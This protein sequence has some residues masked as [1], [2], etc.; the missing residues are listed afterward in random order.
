[1]E[2]VQIMQLLE[3]DPIL[4]MLTEDQQRMLI[5]SAEFQELPAGSVLLHD[6]LLD[7]DLYWLVQ[8]MAK[9]TFT[10]DEGEEIT[11]MFYH[12]GELI[13]LVSAIS[14]R[15]T[16]FS[17]QTLVDSKLY[18][19]PH[20]LF[21]QLLHENY[22]FADKILRVISQRFDILYQEIQQEHSIYA[23][24]MDP[25]PYRK[26]VGEIMTSP[27]ITAGESDSLLD[28]TRSM[29]RNRISSLVITGSNKEVKGIITREDIIRTIATDPQ[30]F[31]DYQARE[32]M[33]THLY[34]L[35]PEA[36][37]YEALLLMA[38]YQI[39]H[40]PIVS[41]QQQLEG[42][43]TIRNLTEARGTNILTVVQ[44]IESA[45]SL[46]EL[47]SN[48]KTIVQILD[49]MSR[50]N[51][52]ALEMCHVI[53]ECNDR[54]TRRILAI[55]EQQLRDEGLGEPPV[56]YCWLTMGSEGR[57]E[58]A[59]GT[60]QDNAIIYEDVTAEKQEAVDHYFAQ[61]AE[62]VVSALEQ[63]GFPRC[64]GNVMATNPKWR[65]SL[66]DWKRGIHRWLESVEGEE[67]RNFT[68]FLDF[69]PVYGQFSLAEEVRAYLIGLSKSDHFLLHRL[70]EDDAEHQVPLGVFGRI[71][72]GKENAQQDR[73]N[74]KHGGVMHIV[75][76]MRIFALREG[77]LE[78]STLD[79]LE[80]LSQKSL[81]SKED[82][83]NIKEA[84]NTFMVLRIRQ[85]LQELKAGKAPSHYLSIKELSKREHIRL[86]KSL[87]TAKWLQQLVSYRLQAGG[88]R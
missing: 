41:N 82:V 49:S 19:I 79:R 62:K 35:P 73:V 75:N 18:R 13:G 65:H 33:S 10:S 76:A 25:H 16:K 43:V 77:I 5:S 20:A 2:S 55:C 83:E 84:F 32:M 29:H 44:K 28:I 3:N 60:D 71:L 61:L 80:A 26:K 86:K 63:C 12:P 88:R 17:I 52:T 22:L 38:K 40:I 27:V 59:L 42:I 64:Q 56:E 54:L 34:T 57:R 4:Q 39:E 85:N 87:S 7:S 14:H 8:G 58:Q 67:L 21:E 81:F 51:A 31:A 24:G 1:M 11:V 6:G 78:V 50:E 72:T 53:T 9:N 30:G 23:T 15:R 66:A 45:P 68:I 70:A 47:I 69:R 36:F 74:I 46:E 37:Y 48:R